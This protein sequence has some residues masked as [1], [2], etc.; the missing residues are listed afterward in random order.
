MRGLAWCAV[1]VAGSLGFE[2]VVQGAEASA[3]STAIDGAIQK[4][5]DAEK[6]SA[7]AAADDAEFLRRAFLDLH[8]VVP[9]PERAA[10][11]LDDTDPQKRAKLIDELLADPRYGVHF[12]D[13]WR[14]A[15][16]S[17]QANEQRMQTDRFVAWVA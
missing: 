13:I 12:G 14:K 15:L 8:G 6:V 3:L 16:V 7:V 17:P 2:S 10:R 1:V 11:F 9:S 4:R 5:L